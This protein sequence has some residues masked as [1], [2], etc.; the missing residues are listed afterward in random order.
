MFHCHVLIHAAFGMVATVSYPGI[1]SQ[2]EMRTRSGNRP[3]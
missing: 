1:D 3:E 2:F